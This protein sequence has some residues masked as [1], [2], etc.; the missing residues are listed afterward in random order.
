MVSVLSLWLPILVSAVFV[1]FVSF[2]LHTI[3]TYHNSDFKALPEEDRVFNALDGIKIPPGDY[4]MPHA[5]DNKT[6][7]TQEF[8]NKVEKGPVALL[9]VMENKMPGMGKTL[10]Q[11]FVYCI[12]ISVFAAYI[13]G[14][15]LGPDADYLAVFRFTGATAFIAYTAALWQD[16]IWYSRK[17]SSTIKSTIDG[18]IF[19]LLTGGVFGWLWA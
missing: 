6:R 4:I 12:I 11:W 9:T 5:P 13:A 8:K 18:L 19:A 15:A 2:I 17:W 14:R 3:F 1:F 10:T 7:Q 16:S